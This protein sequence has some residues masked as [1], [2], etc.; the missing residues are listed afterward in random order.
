MRLHSVEVPTVRRTPRI[1]TGKRCGRTARSLHFPGGPAAREW[2]RMPIY[3]ASE[4]APW[5]LEPNRRVFFSRDTSISNPSREKR[6][7]LTYFQRHDKKGKESQFKG[8]RI[9]W[10]A[11]ATI[12]RM[13]C[14][15][16]SAGLPLPLLRSAKERS[17]G[18]GRSRL[19]P[20][21]SHVVRCVSPQHTRD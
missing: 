5:V 12:G 19:G 21:V 20:V 1:S 3:F 8:L 7:R 16:F 13:G 10:K 15:R 17:N 18:G 4:E 6:P 14:E 9:A 2:T 11:K